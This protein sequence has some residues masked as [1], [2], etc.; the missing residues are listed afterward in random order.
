MHLPEMVGYIKKMLL[1]DWA[2]INFVIGTNPEDFI[3]IKLDISSIDSVKGLHAYMNTL[4]NANDVILH[5]QLRRVFFYWGYSDDD[6]YVY[7]MLAPPWVK[8]PINDEMNSIGLRIQAGKI[9]E[10]NSFRYALAM[11]KKPVLYSKDI[12]IT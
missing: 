4:L 8:V 2:D 7:Y 9:K 5:Y 6:K 11:E 3:E 1:G 10:S 12:E